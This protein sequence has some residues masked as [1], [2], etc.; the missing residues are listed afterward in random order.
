MHAIMKHERFEGPAITMVG[1]HEMLGGNEKKGQDGALTPTAMAAEVRNVTVTD[2][3]WPGGGIIGQMAPV[4]PHTRQQHGHI[5]AKFTSSLATNAELKDDNI[6]SG[7][8][9]YL[10]SS[11]TGRYI[12]V[13][14]SLVQERSTDVWMHI[15][16]HE[17]L[18][19]HGGEPVANC[20]SW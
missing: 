1:N 2:S 15:G 11:S 12:D 7:D 18:H 6:C 17:S 20:K 4:E 19:R 5:R 16:S 9:I 13:N 3:I 10:K 14:G 8:T